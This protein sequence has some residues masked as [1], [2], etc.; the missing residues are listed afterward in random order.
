[1]EKKTS[2]PPWGKEKISAGIIWGKK[3]ENA[4]RKRGKIKRKTKKGEGKKRK[5]ERK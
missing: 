2:P 3:Y 1:L 4:K 5:G